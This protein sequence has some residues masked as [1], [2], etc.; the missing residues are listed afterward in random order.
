MRITMPPTRSAAAADFLSD[1]QQKEFHTLEK[2]ID[3][4]SGR[5]ERNRGLL[6]ADRSRRL[7]GC[8]SELYDACWQTTTQKHKPFFMAACLGTLFAGAAGA[9]WT[10]LAGAPQLAGAIAVGG[11]VGCFYATPR[12]YAGAVKKFVIP[13]QMDKLVVPALEQESARLA[14]SLA[15]AKERRQG[16]LDQA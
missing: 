6:E 9:A 7:A 3:S 2:Q 13:G 5:L 12:L 1:K 16:M 10:S 4:W 15:A 11:L 14:T 8:S